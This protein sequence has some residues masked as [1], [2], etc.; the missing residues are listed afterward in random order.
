MRDGVNWKTNLRRMFKTGFVNFWRNGLISVA[1]IFVVTVTLFIIGS[2][3]L[4]QA[5]LSA[6]LSDLEDKVDINVY[7]KT[8]TSEEEVLAFRERVEAL[9]EVKKVDYISREE[10]LAQFRERNKDNTLILEALEELGENPLGAVFNIRAK[11]PSQYEAIVS[12]L[13][14]SAGSSL[15]S[16]G[17]GGIIDDINYLD[18]RH[19]LAIERLS[20]IIVGARTIGLAIALTLGIMAVLVTFNTIRLAIYNARHEIEVMQLVGAERSFIRGPFVIEGIMYGLA[21]AII[22]IIVFF[23]AT[24]WVSQATTDYFGGINIFH[25]FLSNFWQMFFLLVLVGI[26]LGMISSFIA[27]RRHLK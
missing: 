10:A 5:F 26:F 4:G 19:K 1:S 7:F 15:E 18:A 2:L 14:S 25:Y 24:Y 9:L 8:D 16:S 13:N 6:T 27:V 22:V 23:P 11:D 17:S 12:F 20:K 3:V 21:S